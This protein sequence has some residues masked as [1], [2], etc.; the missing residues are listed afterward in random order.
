MLN[1]YADTRHMHG[2]RVD[3]TS[4]CHGVAL[5]IRIE[6]TRSNNRNMPSTEPLPEYI[7][8]FVCVHFGGLHANTAAR[9]GQEQ[10]TDK[11]TDVHYIDIVCCTLWIPS[12][13]DGQNATCFRTRHGIR[14]LSNAFIGL[15]VRV[16]V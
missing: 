4:V 11:K 9:F 6:S 12:L 10:N 16:Q 14:P 2:S 15:R 5:H 13:Y 7:S 3:A 8:V 1:L